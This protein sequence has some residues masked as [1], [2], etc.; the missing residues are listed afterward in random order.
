MASL[1][2]IEYQGREFQIEG[3][4]N[5]SQDQLKAVIL[6]HTKAEQPIEQPRAQTSNSLIKD[7]AGTYLETPAALATGLVSSI[8]AGIVGLG[9]ILTGKG[10]DTA[11]KNVQAI[12]QAGT[13][14][15]RTQ[16]GQ[17][18]TES[19][20]GALNYIPQK[21]GDYLFNRAQEAGLS[22]EVSAGIGTVGQ[23]VVDPFNLLGFKSV[24]APIVSGAKAV[25]RGAAVVPEIVSSAAKAPFKAPGVVKDIAKG[26][27]VS[28]EP[29]KAPIGETYFTS[30]GV[31][32]YMKGE[33]TK[34]ELNEKYQQPIKDVLTS[35]LEKAALKISGKEVPYRGQVAEATGQRLAEEY[36]SQPYALPLEALSAIGGLSTVGLPITPYAVKRSI[37]GLSDAYLAKKLNLDPAFLEK[38][39]ADKS[40]ENKGVGKLV[41]PENPEE[42]LAT[43][44]EKQKQADIKSAK[45]FLENEI[46]KQ[47]MKSDIGTQAYDTMLENLSTARQNKARNDAIVKSLRD[48]NID[49]DVYKA[50][51]EQYPTMKH[52]DLITLAKVK[53][54]PIAPE[55]VTAEPV[56][57]TTV[58][59]D[60]ATTETSVP[61][62]DPKDAVFPFEEIKNLLGNQRALDLRKQW[63]DKQV[64]PSEFKY[65]LKAE[66]P[67]ISTALEKKSSV[68]NELTNNDLFAGLNEIDT[69]KLKPEKVNPISVSPNLD[70]PTSLDKKFSPVIPEWSDKLTTYG[71]PLINLPKKGQL[72]FSKLFERTDIGTLKDPDTIKLADKLITERVNQYEDY[73]NRL[74]NDHINL[75]SQIQTLGESSVSGRKLKRVL[76]INE[77]DLLDA[78]TG[79]ENA[80]KDQLRWRKRLEEERFTINPSSQPARVKRPDVFEMKI[81]V[82]EIAKTPKGTLDNPFKNKEEYSKHTLFETL[83]TGK[84]AA[85]VYKDYKGNLIEHV[86]EPELDSYGII[87]H[88]KE[89][90]NYKTE[91]WGKDTYGQDA[92]SVFLSTEPL[93]T[94][95][96]FNK[97]GGLSDLI[98]NG[99]KDMLTHDEYYYSDNPAEN[100]WENN[101]L[102]RKTFNNGEEE[103]IEFLP[104]SDKSKYFKEP[105]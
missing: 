24:R 75:K 51:S 11:A 99:F 22:P 2:T 44:A 89:G 90:K 12:Q 74:A 26:A 86:N 100:N 19:V 15:P 87:K 25:G 57:T 52:E 94:N 30:N 27:F 28:E 95:D 54:T 69:S 79:V 32:K 23:L 84:P 49:P 102:H 81:D 63:H 18:A 50:L 103:R 71:D 101:I 14:Q 45:E 10:V 105:D 1:Y 5:A 72:R 8:P 76:K 6:Q 31:D 16:A 70:I 55:T 29:A 92:H 39:H 104:K 77:R 36:K 13:Y 65:W 41:L 96:F 9:D 82:P 34:Q 66:H 68:E 59:P 78:K 4:D 58:A 37:V 21:A 64:D 61:V 97:V 33:I 46:Q 88:S 62:I 40:V 98:E 93:K 35:P 38:Y 80:Y 83:K 67:E 91:V 53:P 20:A 85:G 7:I 47:K 43:L 73:F 17:Q 56:K 3:P 42:A 60:V 48:N